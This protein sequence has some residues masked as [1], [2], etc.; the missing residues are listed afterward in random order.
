MA[1]GG[2]VGAIGRGGGKGFVPSHAEAVWIVKSEHGFAS[3]SSRDG[4]SGAMR[5]VH[6]SDPTLAIDLCAHPARCARPVARL[7]LCSV[8][9]AA[10]RVISLYFVLV[11]RVGAHDSHAHLDLGTP[12]RTDRVGDALESVLAQALRAG[13]GRAADAGRGGGRIGAAVVATRTRDHL[14]A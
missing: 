4:N 11:V 2:G 13:S 12:R 5:L 9:A 14:V 8:V 6:E 7:L 1:E 3:T 10:Q